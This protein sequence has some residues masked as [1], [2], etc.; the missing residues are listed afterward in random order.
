MNLLIFL[1]V[2]GGT[3]STGKR[4][5]RLPT[6]TDATYLVKNVG[7]SNIYRVILIMTEIV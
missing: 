7:G 6:K 2:K 3:Q 5:F 4:R 1:T